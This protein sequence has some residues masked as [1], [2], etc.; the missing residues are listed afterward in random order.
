MRKYIYNVVIILFVLQMSHVQVFANYEKNNLATA[1]S[2]GTLQALISQEVM[3]F[4]TEFSIRY[5]GDV[6]TIKDELTEITKAAIQNDYIYANISSFK[7]KY[8]GTNNN[9][10]ID[11]TFTYHMSQAE[12][13]FVEQTLATIIAPMHG[14]NDL[15]KLQA[16]HDF[17]VLSTEYSKETEGSQYSPYTLL[18][19]NKGVCQ[20]YALVLY[21]MLEMLGFEV[22]YVPGKAGEQLHAWVLVKLD[23]AWYHIDVTWDDP[24]PDHKGEVRYQYF[25]Q[26]DRQLSQDHIWDYMK[27]PAATSEKYREMQQMTKTQN[28]QFSFPHNLGLSAINEH[29]LAIQQPT[30]LV[31]SK[32]SEQEAFTMDEWVLLHTESFVIFTEMLST[33][34]VLKTSS[35]TSIDRVE[36]RMPQEKYVIRKEVPQ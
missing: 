21:R 18:T 29:K 17:I 32:Q 15:E 5:T 10:V 35:F 26:S 4:S 36:K 14:F 13:A 30:K 28:G 22:R 1:D 19:E 27:F 6:A 24:L 9:I 8:N 12:A 16:A 25:L 31:A 20:A 7:W 33:N 2:I 34:I 3:Q 23:H 11:F